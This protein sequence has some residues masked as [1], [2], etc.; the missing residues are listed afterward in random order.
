[1]TASLPLVKVG[2][3]ASQDISSGRFVLPLLRTSFPASIYLRVLLQI[4][5]I[6][7]TS[8]N[9]LSIKLITNSQE[10][11]ILVVLYRTPSQFSNLQA[12]G[13]QVM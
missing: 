11:Q 8:K 12:L 5:V 1:L 13:L 7:I 3:A 10:W 9:T 4:F 6:Y 2:A